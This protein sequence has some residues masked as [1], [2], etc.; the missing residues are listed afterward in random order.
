MTFLPRLNRILNVVAKYHLVEFL[1]GQ[2]GE[3]RLS[4]ALLPWRLLHAGS[5][6][7]KLHRNE[8]LRLAFEELGPIYIKFGQLLSTR[9]DFLDTDL[10]DALQS[11]QDNVPPF[12]KPGI[13]TLVEAALEK[14]VAEVFSELEKTAFASASVA[15]VHKARLLDGEE[16]VVKVIRPGIEKTIE[17]D[18]KLLQWFATILEDNTRI[19]RRLHLVEIVA[20]YEK[21]I[22]DELNLQAEGANTSQLRRNFENS[23]VLYV[24]K[25][26][27]DYTRRNV[28]VMERIHGIPVT[29]VDELREHDIDLKKLAETGVNIFFTQVFE[30]NFFPC[31]YASRQHLCRQGKPRKPAVHRYRLRHHRLAQRCRPGIPRAQPVGDLQARLSQGRRIARG[32][33]LGATTNSYS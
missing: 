21:V 3:R 6:Y 25:V 27:W 15:Q 13:D 17:A 28:L 10:A 16:V 7:R 19:G 30:H 24:P 2:T 22:F 11:L 20:D 26:Y 14:P 18:L 32:Q 5:K 8:R 23:P 9:R 33:R 31:R 12:D 1:D 4:M 29:K